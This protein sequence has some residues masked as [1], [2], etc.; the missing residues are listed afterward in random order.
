MKIAVIGGGISGLA[1]AFYLKRF[2]PSNDITL[3]EAEDQLGGKLKTIN[4][5]GFAIELTNSVFSD[6]SVFINELIKD[7]GLLHHISK[8]SEK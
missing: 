2:S 1:T 3:Y 4:K 7:A 5:F 6:K 8:T